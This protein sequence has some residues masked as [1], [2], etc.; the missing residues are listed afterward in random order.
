MMGSLCDI[1]N[2]L[3]REEVRERLAEK[4]A[5]RGFA[6]QV[7]EAAPRQRGWAYT[8][9]LIENYDHPEFVLVNAK[10]PTG[11]AVLDAL[12]QHVRRGSEL[13]PGDSVWA[14]GWPVDLVQVHPAHLNHGVFDSWLGLYSWLPSPPE[15]S[16]LE[17]VLPPEAFCPCHRHQGAYLETAAPLKPLGNRRMRRASQRRQRRK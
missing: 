12:G 15:F 6:I 5:C 1:C 13:L 10:V 9:G 2:G 17:V 11:A 3:T 14:A 7:V 16:A 4:V 8:V